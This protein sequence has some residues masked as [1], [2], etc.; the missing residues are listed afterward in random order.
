MFLQ[1]ILYLTDF[2]MHIFHS[3]MIFILIPTG[4][5]VQ[6][7][8]NW[9]CCR[10]LSQ[11]DIQIFLCLPVLPHVRIDSDSGTCYYIIKISWEIVK[12]VLG[13][14]THSWGTDLKTI[15]GIW[16]D[17]N[18]LIKGIVKRSKSIKY[19][20]YIK[21]TPIS[22]LNFICLKILVFIIINE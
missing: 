17:K 20:K 13:H 1:C 14:I 22:R 16:K 6:F 10:F 21:V 15:L 5:L 7:L 2:K 4:G 11:Q 8:S 12:F 19:I 18:I 3:F 9:M